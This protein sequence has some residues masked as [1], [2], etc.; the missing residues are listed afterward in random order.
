[1]RVLVVEDEPKL[2]SLLDRGLQGEGYSVDTA[3]NGSDA[4]WLASEFDYDALVLD[5]QIPAPDG[6]EVAREL[7]ERSRWA[8]ILFLTVRDDISDRVEGLDAGGDDYL[9]KP[10]AFDELF[11]R[12][13]ALIRRSPPPRPTILRS[14]DLSLD[15]A[16]HD[17]RRG[18]DVLRLSPKEFSLL[19]YLLRHANEAVSRS[20]ILDHVWD[21]AY[22]GMSNVVDVYI[23]YLRSK[24][25]HERI[26]TVRGVGYR[27]V[28]GSQ[29]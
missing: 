12:L 11:A 19:E 17:A 20:E 15:P 29:A 18:T 16:T 25:G 24:I 14:G 23:G 6:I 21:F 8:P 3:S 10:F 4:V 13:R 28:G 26:E 9:T 1:V 27:L 2:R 22:E 7:R 5:I